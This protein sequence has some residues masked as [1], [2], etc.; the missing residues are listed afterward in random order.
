[1]DWWPARW[2]SRLKA[3]VSKAWLLEATVVS[4]DNWLQSCTKA[5]TCASNDSLKKEKNL[6]KISKPLSFL[7]KGGYSA[8][9]FSHQKIWVYPTPAPYSML[10][11]FNPN[12]IMQ[13]HARWKRNQ[14][15]HKEASD[16][17]TKA[18][19]DWDKVWPFRTN[20]LWG[21]TELVSSAPA[22]IKTL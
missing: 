10:P 21:T 1:M 13:D 11:E 2:L 14:C 16:D 19:S 4:K 20:S 6:Q 15:L 17:I 8:T 7:L 18:T 3:L 22:L 5:C 9:F 12:K